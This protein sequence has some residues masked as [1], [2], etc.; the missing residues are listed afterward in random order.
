[1][2][3]NPLNTAHTSGANLRL[4]STTPRHLRP[5]YCFVLPIFLISCQPAPRTNAVLLIVDDLGWADTG[6][7]GSTFYETPNI[8][9]L[10]EDGVRFLNFYAASP[11]CSPTRASIM[12]GKHPTRINITNWISGEQKGQ[13][14]QAKYDRQLSLEEETFAE[15]FKAEGYSTAFFGK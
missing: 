1:M 14:L 4:K 11:V 13:L 3:F 2:R 15:R 10:A 9:A 12:S 6:I 5:I 8:D 7:Y